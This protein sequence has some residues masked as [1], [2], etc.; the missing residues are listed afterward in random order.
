MHRFILLIVGILALTPLLLNSQAITYDY[1]NSGNRVKKYIVVQK[2]SDHIEE[3]YI[4][5]TL[6]KAN[7]DK[8]VDELNEV[9]VTIY[10]NPTQGQ[11]NIEV[12][13]LASA[14]MMGYQLYSQTGVLLQSQKSAGSYFSVDLSQYPTGIYILILV[15]KD[16]RSEWKVFKK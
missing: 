4:T 8:V 3:E 14:E 13:G 15:N 9:K 5:D 7:P 11:L 10:P 1:D 6:S 2:K 12:S 16:S